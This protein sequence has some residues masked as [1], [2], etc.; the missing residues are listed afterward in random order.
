M[1]E[2][3]RRAERNP[4]LICPATADRI[5]GVLIGLPGVASDFERFYQAC[6]QSCG[7]A[8][9]PWLCCAMALLKVARVAANVRVRR[10]ARLDAVTA[11]VR[12]AREV[13]VKRYLAN[14]LDKS[15]GEAADLFRRARQM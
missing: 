4:R 8:N 5:D 12:S 10:R 13:V 3:V 6:P 11:R 2:F 15:G 1:D 14:A 7:D 9:S